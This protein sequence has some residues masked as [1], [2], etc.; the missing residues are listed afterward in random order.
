M[1]IQDNL[2]KA[3]QVAHNAHA[4]YSQFYVGCVIQ[5]KAGNE[6]HGCN[7]ENISYGLTMCAERVA[8][9]AAVAAEGSRMRL[10][11]VYVAMAH[12]KEGSPCGACRQVI[13]EFGP[14]AQV[15]F[16]QGGQVHSMPASALLPHGF[17][18]L[19]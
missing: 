6:Y 19:E 18:T 7:V 8:I 2:K 11:Q 14:Q 9:G 12:G 4:P 5:T 15:H 17:E 3:E 10:D 1:S 13:A 16:L